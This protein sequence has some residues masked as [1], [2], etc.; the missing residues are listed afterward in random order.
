MSKYNSSTQFEDNL[1]NMNAFYAYCDAQGIAAD[2]DHYESEF[3]QFF[4]GE[5]DIEDYLRCQFEDKEVVPSH[6]LKYIDFDELA[7]DE[8]KQNYDQIGKYLFR[9]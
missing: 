1:M 6:I 5:I 3:N 8:L 2:P 4:I 7:A 9:K